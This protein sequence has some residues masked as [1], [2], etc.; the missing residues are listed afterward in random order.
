MERLH[1]IALLNFAIICNLQYSTATD[2]HN[3]PPTDCCIRKKMRIS[4]EDGDPVVLGNVPFVN[5]ME[6]TTGTCGCNAK[7]LLT[8]TFQKHEYGDPYQGC[9]KVP[10]CGNKMLRIDLEMAPSK[11]GVSFHVGDSRTNNGYKGDAS[12]QEKDAEFHSLGYQ[13]LLHGSDHCP[14][15]SLVMTGLLS[16]SVTSVT[17]FIGNEFIRV[18]NN[19]GYVYELCSQCLF[20]LNGQSDSEGPVNEDIFIGLNRIIDSSSY[21][22]GTGVCSAVV[23]WA[24]PWSC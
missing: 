7:I 2:C 20:S 8:A 6:I 5:V 19:L 21:R 11:T 22:D 15:M 4:L 24:C 23:S 10:E 13:H 1:I 17:I 16:N 3:P 9:T 14:N 12:T 18:S